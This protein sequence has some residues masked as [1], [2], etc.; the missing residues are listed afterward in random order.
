MQAKHSSSD[1]VFQVEAVRLVQ[2]SGPSMKQV[3]KDLG[4]AACRLSRWC[5]E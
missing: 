5:Q 3:A 4:V 1:N 2:T